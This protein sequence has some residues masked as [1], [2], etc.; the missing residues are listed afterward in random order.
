[1]ETSYLLA[2]PILAPGY[3]IMIH[4]TDNIIALPMAINTEK[5]AAYA[6]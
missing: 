6:K 4:S 1:M 3:P 2:T 5:A